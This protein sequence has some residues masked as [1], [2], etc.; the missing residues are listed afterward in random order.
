MSIETTESGTFGTTEYTMSFS[1]GG[2]PYSPWHDA[3]L[4]LEGGL[5]NMLTEIPKMTKEKMEVRQSAI[6]PCEHRAHCTD[7]HLT[8][9]HVTRPQVV[10]C[11]SQPHQS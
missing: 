10:G 8:V 4:K 11:K 1:S 6:L 9:H 7:Q 2:K 3:P 5:Y